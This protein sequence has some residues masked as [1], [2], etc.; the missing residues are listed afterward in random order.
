MI[1]LVTHAGGTNFTP[2]ITQGSE[3]GVMENFQRLPRQLIE[4]GNFRYYSSVLSVTSTS[5]QEGCQS[6]K[7]N[8]T[9]ETR[10]VKIMQ[11]VWQK[12][13]SKLTKAAKFCDY[14][15]TKFLL[16]DAS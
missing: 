8:K 11:D 10:Y 3:P 4:K 6:H 5:K 13:V 16:V 15:I 14:S 1:C 12:V 7:P 9:M 2:L